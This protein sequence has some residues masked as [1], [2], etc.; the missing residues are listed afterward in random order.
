MQRQLDFL[1]SKERE[2]REVPETQCVRCAEEYPGDHFQISIS[3][4]S[5][6]N[7]RRNLDDLEM[8]AIFECSNE[9]DAHKWPLTMRNGVPW[10]QPEMPVIASADLDSAVQS[11]LV[12][13]IKEAEEAHFHQLFKATTVMCR[14]AVQ[15]SLEPLVPK[16]K[17]NT[18]GPLL[19]NAKAMTPPPLTDEGF[20]RANSILKLGN[21]GAHREEII[22]RRDAGRAIEDA[23]DV[24][25][26]LAPKLASL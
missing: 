24:L 20:L 14:R 10:G 8:R 18:L 22:A 23:V 2:E 21:A 17:G 12:Q 4:T 15:L 3:K 6:Y 9:H 5:N 26:E 1:C 19:N 11:G 25:N 7:N 13:D 16:G